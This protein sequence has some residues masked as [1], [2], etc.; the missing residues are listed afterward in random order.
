MRYGLGGQAERTLKEV[1]EKMNLSR[2]RVRQIEKNAI[3]K[4]RSGR[5]IGRSLKDYVA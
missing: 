4:I 3:A 2:E 5:K 1:G